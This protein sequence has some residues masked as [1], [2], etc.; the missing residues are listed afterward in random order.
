MKK[1]TR[2]LIRTAV[3]DYVKM[4]PDEYRDLLYT[5]HIQKQNMQDEMATIKKTHAIK[6]ALFTISEKLN[7]MIEK[8]LSTDE[9]VE[10]KTKDGGRWFAKEYPQFSLTKKV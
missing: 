2:M 5:I 8:K 1:K 3:A 9:L 7:A 10:F 4:F 6:R